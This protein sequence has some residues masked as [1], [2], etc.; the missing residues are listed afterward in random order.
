MS[1]AMTQ[2]PDII[3]P[4]FQN[5]YYADRILRRTKD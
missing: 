5:D 4:G 1:L 3:Q 2:K